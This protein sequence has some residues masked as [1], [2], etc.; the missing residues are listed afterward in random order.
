VYDVV[1]RFLIPRKKKAR[2]ARDETLERAF[3]RVM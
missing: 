3:D 2:A 1:K